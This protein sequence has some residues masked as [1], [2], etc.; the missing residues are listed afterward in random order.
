MRHRLSS[1]VSPCVQAQLIS[2][3]LNACLITP[4]VC[5]LL[6][7]SSCKMDTA[8]QQAG[9]DL[10]RPSAS[11]SHAV[12]VRLTRLQHGCPVHYLQHSLD[13]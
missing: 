9:A 2:Q 1:K 11:G 3:C 7:E 8:S 10:D 4:P 13:R 6:F 12:A 5:C